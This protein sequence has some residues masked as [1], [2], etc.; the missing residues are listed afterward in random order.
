ML[1]SII[2]T[3]SRSLSYFL[4]LSY[5]HHWSLSVGNIVLLLYFSFPGR[6]KP[7]YWKILSL[8]HKTESRLIDRVNYI[9]LQLRNH[10]QL[11]PIFKNEKRQGNIALLLK[12]E[13]YKSVGCLTLKC[14]L[15]YLFCTLCYNLV[16]ACITF[17]L[18]HFSSLL[19]FILSLVF[20]YF[21]IQAD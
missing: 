5:V 7:V 9:L 21:S 3:Q 15:V 14:L 17:H 4:F 1:F 19:I 20:F 10:K 12:E 2:K 18:N 11:T 16:W 8:S 13:L 6:L